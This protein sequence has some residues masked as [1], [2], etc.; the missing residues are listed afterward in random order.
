MMVFS[1]SSCATGEYI[2]DRQDNYDIHYVEI[3]QCHVSENIL[4]PDS[5]VLSPNREFILLG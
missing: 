1:V 4:E 2:T 5:K 3:L